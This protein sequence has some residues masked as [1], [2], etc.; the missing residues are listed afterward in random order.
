MGKPLLTD[1]VIEKAK[2]G[3]VFE[4]DDYADLDTKIMTF[5][6]HGESERIYKSRRIENAKRSQFQ[7]TL[8]LVL[9]L[10]VMLI[11][12]LAYAVFYL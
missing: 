10:V 7:S 4:S 3:E 12:L 2:R 1:D 5:E 6:D 9:I 8:N 11:G